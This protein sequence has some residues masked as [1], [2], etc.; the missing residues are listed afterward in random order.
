M[1]LFD[2]S[3][4]T[5]SAALSV[6]SCPPDDSFCEDEYGPY[7]APSAATT[8]HPD[9]RIFWGGAY[10][11]P[12]GLYEVRD[13]VLQP[14]DFYEPPYWSEENPLWR[15]AL[16]CESRIECD[17][18]GGLFETD[19]E[20]TIDWY[21]TIDSSGIMHQWVE[22]DYPLD[23]PSPDGWGFPGQTAWQVHWKWRDDIDADGETLSAWHVLPFKTPW[24]GPIPQPP[25]LAV[26]A[27]GTIWLAA[28]ALASLAFARRRQQQGASALAAMT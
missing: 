26:S 27:P 6:L 23:Y 11:S 21:F 12:Y 2:F 9:G 8:R 14:V 7:G 3:G 25:S 18:L 13:E 15:F 22:W 24:F 16:D 1:H 17:K 28:L 20:R 19:D 5:L 4:L 10:G